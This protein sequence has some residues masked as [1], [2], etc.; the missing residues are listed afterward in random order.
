MMNYI[1]I[2]IVAYFTLEWSVPKGSGTPRTLEFG[3]LPI[4]FGQKYLFNILFVVIITVLMYIYL[5]YSKQGYE[6]SVV[7]ES[8]NTAKYVGIN[9]GK[10]IVRTMI[11]SGVLCGIVGFILVAGIDH[12][13]SETTVGGLGFTAIMASWLAKFNPLVMIGSSAFIAFLNQGS[14]EV[15]TMFNVN[16]SFPDVVV[17]IFLFFIIGCEF[18]INYKFMRRENEPVKVHTKGVAIK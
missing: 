5:K 8:E 11:I 13:V 7:G 2:Q 16:S 1:A 9:V 3:Q 18:F 12:S 15:S 4:L 10:V 14:A 6:I 17:G